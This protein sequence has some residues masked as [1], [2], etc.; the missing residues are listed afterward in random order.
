MIAFFL[1][2]GTIESFYV[3]LLTKKNAFYAAG[4]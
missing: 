3:G 1:P 4:V 2:N